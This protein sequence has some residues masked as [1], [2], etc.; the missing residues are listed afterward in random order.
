MVKQLEV[1]KLK[2]DD[3]F[4][5]KNVGAY[6]ITEGIALFLSRDMPKVVL[7]SD[8]KILVRDTINSYKINC[9]NYEGEVKL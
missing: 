4:I 8:K 9:P 2:I 1:P 6:S 5:F 3:V 7:I